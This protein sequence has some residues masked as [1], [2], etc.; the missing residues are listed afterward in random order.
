[1]I[2]DIAKVDKKVPMGIDTPGLEGQLKIISTDTLKQN[3]FK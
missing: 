3:E 1:M 2:K